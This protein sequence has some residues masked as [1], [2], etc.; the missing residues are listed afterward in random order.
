MTQTNAAGST[1]GRLW[2]AAV[3]VAGIGFGG[4][5]GGGLGIGLVGEASAQSVE[6]L[7]NTNCM[8]CHGVTGQG[9][10]ASSL[11]D[12]EWL[13]GP[14]DKDLFR[15]TKEGIA[16]S[17]M[18]AYGET[19]N[20]AQLWG[21]VV[22][23]RELRAR[24]E[25][26]AKGSPRPDGS[27]VYTSTHARFRVE[28][29]VTSGLEVPWGVDFLPDA[30]P[31]G[32]IRSGMLVANRPGGLHLWNDGALSAAVR[33][34]PDVRN[35]G[36]GGLMEVAVHPEYAEN[37][38]IYLGFSHE[39]E[40]NRRPGMTKIVRG[41]IRERG[42]SLQ[43]MDE[44][45]I[46][47]ARHEDYLTTD[48]HFGCRIVFEEGPDG[49]H[50]VYF[51][52][53]ERGRMEHAQE[54]A[55]PNGKVFRVYDDGSIPLDNPF[56]GKA[57]VYEQIWSYGHRNPQGLVMDLEGRLWD[58]EHGPRGGDELNL[59]EK[60]KNYGW[61]L[62][63]FGMNYNGSPFA[64]PWPKEGQDLTMPTYVWTPSIAA[65][66]LDVV[67]AGAKGEAFGVWRGDLMAG[68]LA[69]QTVQR[70][71]IKDG[72]VVEIEELLHGDGRVRDVAVGPDGSVYVVYNGPDVIV[73]MVPVQ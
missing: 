21:L 15:A 46:F 12:D 6:Q 23:M 42:S 16:D 24:H 17:G 44:E 37:G 10:N 68:G 7:W 60:G 48:L 41:K 32:L 27:G 51:A 35:R 3:V 52:I 28:R 71:R 36:Q 1:A 18:P 67:R 14:T 59:V 43:W 69:G 72:E 70:L 20:D 33:G 30:A 34:T 19:L 63:S 49:K 5:F 50:Y 9:A 45:V 61:P 64:T 66:G 58:T 38:W 39:I 56:V 25:R 8:S 55:R 26:A 54:L 29:V 13:L 47:E 22:H 31:E 62:V 65:C 73:R 53:G 2:S 57:G 11:L 40:G 4:G